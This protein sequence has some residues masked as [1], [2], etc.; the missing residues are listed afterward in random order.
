MRACQMVSRQIQVL[1][2][3]SYMLLIS[4]NR[5]IRQNQP[6]SFCL[7]FFVPNE[8]SW[9]DIR[10]NCIFLIIVKDKSLSQHVILS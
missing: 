3:R 10:C 7:F 6:R 8:A 1:I 4:N 2:Q 9:Y 5:I